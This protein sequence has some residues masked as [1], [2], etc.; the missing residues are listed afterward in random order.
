MRRGITVAPIVVVLVLGSLLP[1]LAS[2]A[3]RRA[4]GHAHVLRINWG[5]SVPETLDPQHSDEGQWSISGGLDYE[6]LTRIDEKLQVVPGAAESWEFS[7]DGKTL[8]F[9]LRDGL[10]YQRR[11]AGHRR[12]LSSTPPSGSAAPSSTRA[13][14]TCSSTSSAVRSCSIAGDAGRG[15]RGQGRRSGCTPWTTARWSTSSPGP[16][17]TSWRWRRSGAPSRCAR[18]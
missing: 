14:R 16:R 6:G 3:A 2:T 5:P 15:G 18:T 1:G 4:A 9:H 17:R 7:P 13:R 11:R 10:V 8:T 12:A